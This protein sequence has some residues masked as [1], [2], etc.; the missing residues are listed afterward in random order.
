MKGIPE[1]GAAESVGLG[2]SCHRSTSLR[3]RNSHMEETYMCLQ[4]C[5]DAGTPTAVRWREEQSLSAGA[6]VPAAGRMDST[7]ARFGLPAV[8]SCTDGNC[9]Y[10][11]YHRTAASARPRAV[12]A[13]ATSVRRYTGRKQAAHPAVEEVHHHFAK[14]T[15]SMA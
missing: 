15:Q 1:E 13:P 6:T 5:G 2:S 10:R 3:C 8:E 12:P 14:R 7:P 4:T 9:L 11:Y